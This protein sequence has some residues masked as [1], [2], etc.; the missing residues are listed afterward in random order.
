MLNLNSQQ[1]KAINSNSSCILCLA[2]AGT[3]KTKTLV[4]RIKRL[5]KDGINPK[6]IIAITFTKHA[7][8]EMKQRINVSGVFIDTFHAWCLSVL[9]KYGYLIGWNGS[10]LQIID[11][12]DQKNILKTIQ[13]NL[14]IKNTRNSVIKS[15]NDK[16]IAYEY[17]SFL[18][19]NDIID[20]DMIQTEAFLILSSKVEVLKKKSSIY[21][22]IDEFQDTDPIQYKIIKSLFI[23]TSINIFAVGDDAQSIYG[24]RGARVKNI[25]DF[26]FEC[27]PEIITL[28]QNYRSGQ[29]IL[30]YVNKIP[31][32]TVIK[33]QLYSDI[34]NGD[35]KIYEFDDIQQEAYWISKK[36]EQ[37][38]GSIGILARTNF[39]VDKFSNLLQQENIEFNKS[40]KNKWTYTEKNIINQIKA[41][42]SNN[43]IWL[44]GYDILSRTNG[45]KDNQLQ[46]NIVIPDNTYLMELYQ[47]YKLIMEMTQ[48][49]YTDQGFLDFI[50]TQQ[51]E[52]N[53]VQEGVNLMTIHGA[54]GLEFDN[55]FIVGCADSI[56]PLNSEKKGEMFKEATRLFYVACTRAKSNLFI[57]WPKTCYIWG[58]EYNLNKSRLII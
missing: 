26:V 30:N 4:E 25:Q 36:T 19:S 56:F 11:D 53:K 13:K 40:T 10:K 55:V 21:F 12:E 27:R 3:G 58:N 39:Y 6:H 52:E 44:K 14:G 17:K 50:E 28:E 57:S 35:I 23:N 32:N 18:L 15:D 47:Q 41:K 22:M 51:D 29:N 8:T 7:A 43:E 37:L 24:F 5:I 1:Q 2:G 16:T 45:S 33:K 34:A 31:V 46:K 42:V 20:Y 54:K 38:S 49:T 48:D 9:R